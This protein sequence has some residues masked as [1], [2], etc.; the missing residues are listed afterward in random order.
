VETVVIGGRIV[1]RDRK[2]LTVNEEEAMA[3]A[4]QYKKSIAASL[5]MK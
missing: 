1:L 4:R 5:G 3:R 2:L